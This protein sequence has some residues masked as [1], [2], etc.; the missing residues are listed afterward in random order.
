M[1]KVDERLKSIS[2]SHSPQV[3]DQTLITEPCM[4]SNQENLMANSQDSSRGEGFNWF[5]VPPEFNFLV[6]K[7][8]PTKMKRHMNS[9]YLM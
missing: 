6:E 8:H 5:M 1:N 2:I 9:G 3:I 7:I 4:S